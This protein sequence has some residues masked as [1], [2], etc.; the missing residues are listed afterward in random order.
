MLGSQA[1]H[2]QV[3]LRVLLHLGRTG[4][5]VKPS[6]VLEDEMGAPCVTVGGHLLVPS[7]V[8]EED[9]STISRGRAAGLRSPPPHTQHLS[10]AKVALTSAPAG[11]PR[12]AAPTS[13]CYTPVP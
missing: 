1:S 13:I 10:A 8:R 9:R 4:K 6:Q 2:G 12:A 3:A 7:T 5:P 11:F